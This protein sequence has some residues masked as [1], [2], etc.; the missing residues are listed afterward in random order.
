MNTGNGLSLKYVLLSKERSQL[1]SFGR[2]LQQNVAPEARS[3]G[4]IIP[5][6]FTA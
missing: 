5:T 6:N 1:Q 4:A 2:S 3:D